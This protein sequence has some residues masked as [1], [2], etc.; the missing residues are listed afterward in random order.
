MTAEERELDP[1]IHAQLRLAIMTL[2]SQVEEADF[3][4]LRE[5]LKATDGNL[6]VHARKLEDAGYLTVE[7]RFVDRTPRTIYRLHPSGRAAY[8]RYL[9]ALRRLLGSQLE[10]PPDASS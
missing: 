8:A 9:T 3:T 7:K 10:A 5:H 4:W 1:V 6:S 2:L